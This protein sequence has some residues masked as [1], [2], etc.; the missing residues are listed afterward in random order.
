MIQ[1]FQ[2]KTTPPVEIKASIVDR[3]EISDNTF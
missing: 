1:W 3:N 2:L